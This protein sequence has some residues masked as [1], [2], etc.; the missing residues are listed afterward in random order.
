MLHSP[1]SKG[2][3]TSLRTQRLCFQKKLYQRSFSSTRATASQEL[4]FDPYKIGY[5][6]SIVYDTLVYMHHTLDL[7]WWGC[8]VG[9]TIAGRLLFTL[10]V[11]VWQQRHLVKLYKLQEAMNPWLREYTQ[12]ELQNFS[13]SRRGRG[14]ILAMAKVKTE[15]KA[16]R[17]QLYSAFNCR[18]GATALLP[19]VQI[20]F[21]VIMSLTL[22]NMAAFPVP[23]L[24]TAPFPYPGFETGGELWFRNL[25]VPDP[26][27]IFGSVTGLANFVTLHLNMTDAANRKSLLSKALLFIGRGI[28]LAVIP[29]ALYL[30]AGV[31]IYWATSALFGLVQAV[32]FR[33]YRMVNRGKT[34]PGASDYIKKNF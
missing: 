8:I 21:F 33:R 25:V 16:K 22:R 29:I 31:S 9:A 10:P 32:A 30:P 26:S 12:R 1:V 7:P 6:G 19:L 14:A 20:P 2:V 18:P 34:L 3:Y 5:G 28:T 4:F 17:K 13:G 11:A 23:F 24:E 27:C 15:L